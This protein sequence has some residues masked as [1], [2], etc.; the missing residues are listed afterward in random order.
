MTEP[1]IAV[2]GCTGKLGGRVA[3]QLAE[4]G[5][6]QRLIVRDEKRAPQLAG[7]EVRVATY[8]DRDA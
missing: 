3:R 8:Q 1:S 2:T 6:P 7:A 4:K 5:V